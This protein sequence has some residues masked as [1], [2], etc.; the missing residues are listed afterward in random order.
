MHLQ[1]QASSTTW[2]ETSIQEAGREEGKFGETQT[3]RAAD[4][5]RVIYSDKK[6]DYPVTTETDLILKTSGKG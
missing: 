3:G 6:S 2:R 1:V 4:K 5:S